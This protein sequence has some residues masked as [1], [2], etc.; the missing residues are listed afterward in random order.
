MVNDE[1]MQK[2][3]ILS[4]VVPCYNEEEMLLT[5][6]EELQKVFEKLEDMETELIFVDDGSQDRT[7]ALIKEFR[8]KDRSVKYLSFSRNFG[9]EAAILAGLEHASGDYTAVMD[10]DLQDP[11]ELLFRM[12][13]LLKTTDCDCAA[14]RRISRDGEPVIRSFFSDVFYRLMQMISD[15]DMMK[16]A[17]DFRLMKR[18]VVNAVISMQEY[19]RFS[20]G[21]FGWVGFRTKWVEYTNVERRSGKTKWSFWK[22]FLYSLEGIMAFSSALLQISSFVGIGLF[23]VSF[24]MILLIIFRTMVFGDPVSG[25]PSMV[26]IITFIGGIQLLSIGILGQYLSRVYLEV[27]HRPIYIVREEGMEEEKC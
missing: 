13:E 1:D 20:K 11:P 10:A 21:I 14:A 17:R 15:V 22:L 26:C 24:V 23:A 3:E 2:R 4:I 16:G 18:S 8:E 9:K 12:L 19:H 25:W 6:Y 27:K 7:L 5:F